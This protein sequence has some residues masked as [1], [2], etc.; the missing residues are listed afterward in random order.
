WIALHAGVAS[1][2][3]VILVPEIPFDLNVVAGKCAERSKYGKRF[4]IIA[5][6]E[7][8]KCQGGEMIVDHVDPTSPDPIRLGGVGK[9]VAEQISNCTGLE[10]RHIVLGHIQRGGTPSAR[11]RVLGTL[12]GTHAVRLL[13]EGKY[14]QLVV[15]KAGQITSVPI[16]EIA[17]KIRTIEPD[18]TL[19]A[20]ARAVGTC[21][22][23]G[24]QA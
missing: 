16:A 9:Y 17:G 3:D 20:A 2:A 13:T 5:V 24:S 11:D 22:G 18:D 14:N 19:L 15:Q 23:D 21:F 6:A 10:S 1:G 7:G 4:T 12:F 8:A